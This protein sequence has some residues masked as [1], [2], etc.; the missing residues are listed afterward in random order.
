MPRDEDLEAEAAD[1]LEL[2]LKNGGCGHKGKH[3]PESSMVR[4]CCVIAFI[5]GTGSENVYPESADDL[6]EEEDELP[7]DDEQPED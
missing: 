5:A 6:D 4:K 7:S 1:A 2:F 3:D